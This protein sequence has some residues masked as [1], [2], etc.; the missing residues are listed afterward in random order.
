MSLEEIRSKFASLNCTH[1]HEHQAP[2]S[3]ETFPHC[4]LQVPEESLKRCAIFLILF[5]HE[6]KFHVLLTIR[7]SQLKDFP[8]ELCFPGGKFDTSVDTSFRDTALREAEEEIGLRKENIDVLCEICP[9]ISPVGHYIAPIIGIVKDDTGSY[10]DTLKVINNLKPNPDEVESLFWVPIDYVLDQDTKNSQAK[11]TNFD[12]DIKFDSELA[13]LLDMI[14]LDGFDIKQRLDSR[15]YQR[16]FLNFDEDMFQSDV[17]PAFTFIYGI[18]AI[19]LLLVSFI[20]E[21]DDDQGRE[22]FRLALNGLIV[23][24]SNITEYVK[25]FRFVSYIMLRNNILQKIKKSKRSKL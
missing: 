15:M 9:V 13:P 2:L 20:L 11:F 23:S 5:R 18:N 17:K 10:E 21:K 14:N 7:S 1:R 8:G 24:K 4:Q 16:L 3:Y 25:F 19:L 22:K 12:T 6:S